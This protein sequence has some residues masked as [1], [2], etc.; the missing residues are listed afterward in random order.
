MNLGFDRLDRYLPVAVRAVFVERDAPRRRNGR[1]VEEQSESFVARGDRDREAVARWTGHPHDEPGRL[2]LGADRERLEA[3]NDIADWRR[4]RDGRI[5]RRGRLPTAR[6]APHDP[7]ATISRVSPTSIDLRP[8]DT[9][10]PV[11]SQ[12][13]AATCIAPRA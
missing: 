6:R 1:S 8:F 13:A 7:E 9:V 11:V 12:A 10:P 2:P 4:I 5:L 3:G